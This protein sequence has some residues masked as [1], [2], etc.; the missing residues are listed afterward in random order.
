MLSLLVFDFD[1]V[2]AES[3]EAKTRAY[4]RLAEP[5]GPEAQDRLTLYHHLH[6]G[7]SRF[8]K[9]KWMY[10]EFTGRDCTE[11]EL[12]RNA[13]LFASFAV[14]EVLSAPMVP[15]ALDVLERWHGRVPLYVCSGTPQE[16]LGMILEKRGLARY[17]KGWRGTPPAKEFLLKAIVDGEAIDPDEAVMVGDSTTDLDAALYAGTRFYGRGEFFVNSPH[18][19]HH[20]LTKLNDWLETV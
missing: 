20:D 10:K 14:D 3:V 5:L 18:P 1:G 11:E 15:G 19:H 8:E 7:V 4:H 13:D 16:E 17:F 9:I 12:R 6:G 2:I